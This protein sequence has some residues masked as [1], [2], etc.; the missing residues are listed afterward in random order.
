MQRLSGKLR[1]WITAPV[2]EENAVKKLF[3]L[4]AMEKSAIDDAILYGMIAAGVCVAIIG[5]VQGL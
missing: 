4:F 1:A 2:S 5:A 3:N